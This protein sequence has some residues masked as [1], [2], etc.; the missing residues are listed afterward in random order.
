MAT[1]TSVGSGLWSVAGTW[2]TGVPLDND[3]V[4]ISAGHTVEFDVDQSGFANG[5]AGITVTGTLKMS[6]T[7]NTHLKMK[8]STTITG[9][10]TFSAGEVGAPI[11]F[12]VKCTITG[13]ADWKFVSTSNLIVNMYGVEPTNKF[14]TISGSEAIGQTVI[15]VDTDVTG[16]I[17]AIGDIVLITTISAATYQ[18]YTIANIAATEITLSSGLTVAK[19]LGNRMY[20]LSRNLMVSAPTG[21][22]NHRLFDTVLLNSGGG[23][24]SSPGGII[25]Y[26]GTNTISGGVFAIGNH[27][28][29][30][31]TLN[32]SGG[33]FLGSANYGTFNTTINSTGAT[34]YMSA[35][36][37]GIYTFAGNV[38][39]LDSYDNVCSFYSCSYVVI[40]NVTSTRAQ[41]ALQAVCNGVILLNSTFTSGFTNGGASCKLI[42]CTI[43]NTGFVDSVAYNVLFTGTISA[44]SLPVNF[45]S[46][47]FDHN[48]VSGGYYCGTKGGTTLK[49]FTTKP[50]GYANS[51]Q[52][53]LLSA[54]AQGYW[55]K[56]VVIGSG[57]S[58]NI[59]SWLRKD[60]SMIY[61]P[62]VIIFDKNTT[63]PLIGGAGLHTFTMTNS[64]DTWESDLY[65]YTNS[66]SEDITLVI[67]CQGMNATGNMYSLADVEQINVDLTSA[68]ALLNAIKPQT[69]LIPASPAPANEYDVRMTAIQADLDN[70]NQYKA[71]V[72]ALALESTLTALKGL[73]WTD[74]TLVALMT[75]IEAI[76]SIDEAGVR[77]AIGMAT[78]NLDTQLAAIPNGSTLY[79]GKTYEELIKL[80][81]SAL[82]GLLSIS[83]DGTTL[84]FRDLLDTKNR[85][86]TTQNP[87]TGERT[88]QTLDGS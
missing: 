74:E 55:Q 40:S 3:V 84:T 50:T 63:D 16:D 82:L 54:S 42:N 27:L 49:Q 7:V 68:I 80:T 86:V 45:F 38:D 8:A 21:A 85:I 67:R 33:L 62:R 46:E 79:D 41:Y 11:P 36:N 64:I 29:W 6:I 88:N 70:P 24:F 53:A 69:D 87:A 48:K 22:S 23:Y 13:G 47:S 34:W 43:G 60:A 78:A 77:N 26:G 83:V 39:G 30:G 61:L 71:D 72:S 12:S 18:T 57:A 37:Q 59:T 31:G 28:V 10:G 15:S 56:S 2:D 58:V 4:I 1:R 19:A 76:T 25:I 51:M 65:T 35:T 20:L 9:T 75:A 52:T 14:V 44:T 66:T 17:W 5:I 32:L 81:A 73:G